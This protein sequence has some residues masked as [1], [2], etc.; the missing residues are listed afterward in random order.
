[1]VVVRIQC[2]RQIVGILTVTWLFA[3]YMMVSPKPFQ[4]K[5]PHNALQISVHQRPIVNVGFPKSGS[6]SL[7]EFFTCTGLRTQHFCC[8][9]DKSDHPPCQTLSMAE[10]I[11]ANMAKG[12]S[13]LQGCGD[14]QAYTQIDGERPTRNL[15]GHMTGILKENGQY[16]KLD[17]RTFEG[18]VSA[19]KHFLPQHFYLDDL[20]KWNPDAIY[21]LPL[22]DPDEWAYSV[23]NWFQMRARVVNEYRLFNSSLERPGKKGARAF[24]SRIYREHTEY[25]R[26]FVKRH[27]RHRL[28]EFNITD[29]SA[30]QILSQSI[31]VERGCW[32]HH[33]MIGDRAN[34]RKQIKK[35]RI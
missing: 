19:F 10:C 27:P 24:L 35:T 2:G 6:T 34:F 23:F 25:V 11:L 7:F 28:V 15:G 22:R 9:G 3:N 32:G 26:S 14:Y 1:M 13:I 29:P 18:R 20:H 33:N 21:V 4:S 8:C 16:D 5:S 31:G 17:Q 12:Q 30:D